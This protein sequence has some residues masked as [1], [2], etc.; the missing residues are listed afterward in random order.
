M[1]R[2]GIVLFL[3]GCVVLI[4]AMDQNNAYASCV[5]SEGLPFDLESAIP[6]YPQNRTPLEQQ[7]AD[8]EWQLQNSG[9]STPLDDT[10]F[11]SVKLELAALYDLLPRE[12]NSLDDG[13]DACPAVALPA[14]VIPY[15]DY[16]TTV[17]AVNNFSSSACGGNTAPDK[18]YSYTPSYTGYFNF[19]TF[20]SNFDTQLYVRTGG[21]CPGSTEVAC[22]DDAFSSQSQVVVLLNGGQTYYVIVDGFQ[23]YSGNFT[24]N[25]TGNCLIGDA[26]D[27]QHECS[28]S[29]GDPS[30]AVWD[31]NGGCNNQWNGGFG[32]W[33]PVNLCQFM[34]GNCFTYQDPNNFSARDID[35]YYFTLT[36]ACSLRVN[37][38]SS[39]SYNVIINDYGF[40][41]GI[42]YL[43]LLNLPA[44][45]G[46]TYVTQCLPAGTYSIDI[47]PNFFTGMATPQ[48]YLFSLEPIPCSGCRI[49]GS[50]RAP[51]SFTANGCE[52]HSHNSLRP[53]DE[54]TYCVIIP[55]ASD[56]TFTLCGSG[57]W[58]SY[59]YL[60]SE[61]SGGIIAQDNDGCSPGG[62][63]KIEC[64]SLMPGNYYL[65][66]E[67]FNAADCG[68][69]YLNAYECVGSCCYGEMWNPSCSYGSLSSCDAL[70]GEFTLGQQCTPGLCYPR[71][72]CEAPSAFSQ[73]PHVPDESWTALASDNYLV[74]RVWEDYNATGWIKALRFWGLSL[75]YNTGLACT[76]QPGSFEITFVDSSNGPQVQTY[77]VQAY[78]LPLLQNYG[79][80][81]VMTEYNVDLP[82]VCGIQSGRISIRG[83]DSDACVWH[84]ATSPQGNS[85]V[86]LVNSGGPL[87]LP[88]DMA[89]CMEQGCPAPD[90]VTI[91][92]HI[93]YFTYYTNF[94][95][96]ADGFLCVYYSD[97]INSVYPTNYTQAFAPIWYPAG[98]YIYPDIAPASLNR[99]YLVTL[100]CAPQPTGAALEQGPLL[101]AE[102]SK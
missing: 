91:N 69:F 89:I 23:S 78:G 2:T 94:R 49:D 55:H 66:I 57:E 14:G 11:H 81:Y 98:W 19:N 80:N 86:V 87:E 84:W 31:C 50:F 70:G 90:S 39:F 59:L 95:T 43:S 74:N 41:P 27:W 12:R 1:K 73:Q 93:N 24:L 101:Q 48:P 42:N 25:I 20:G 56:W 85:S 60:T 7:I 33:E 67:G 4:D 92:V 46:G 82:T 76:E 3:L 5:G 77:N 62:L 17:G 100:N 88:Y 52:N 35:S 44:C 45:N 71:P 26:N 32:Q 36:E 8:L 18:I 40:C 37:V 28:E 54:A 63:S 102:R 68:Q 47:S 22:N 72:G 13:A 34:R 64:I 58:N 16:G 10:T 38:Y 79:A 9:K 65:T 15:T 29:V 51:A 99:R 96:M 30:H 61:C 97:S 6:T 53:S 83:S 21:A 75:D